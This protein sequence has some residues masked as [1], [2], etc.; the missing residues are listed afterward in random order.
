MLVQSIA[1]CAVWVCGSCVHEGVGVG[2][3]VGVWQLCA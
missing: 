2:V 1:V 3:G